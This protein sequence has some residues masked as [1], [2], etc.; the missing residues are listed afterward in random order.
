[1]RSIS[2]KINSQLENVNIVNNN[3][4]K[5]LLRIMVWSFIALTLWYI[6][7]LGNMV[8]NIVERKSLEREAN[9][10]SNEVHDL[11]ITYLSMSNDINLDFSHSLGF[12][13][14][15]AKFATRKSLGSLKIAKNEI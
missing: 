11:E 2:S 14:A 4:E 8:F 6:L 3:V 7:I 10:L 5:L 12:N 15:K 9:T 13:E 1:M